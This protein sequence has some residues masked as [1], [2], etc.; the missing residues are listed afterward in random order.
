MMCLRKYLYISTLI[1]F[2]PKLG[3]YQFYKKRGGA[4]EVISRRLLK[5]VSTGL[6]FAS[7]LRMNLTGL[8]KG[9]THL[10]GKGHES[11]RTLISVLLP[12]VE[13]LLFFAISI[14]VFDE[15]SRNL[16]P[17]QFDNSGN[18]VRGPGEASW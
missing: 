4:F 2:H 5:Q 9:P 3:R 12:R 6:S 1:N 18:V 8:K 16:F 15:N 11:T 10:N 7:C 14:I 13:S 17:S